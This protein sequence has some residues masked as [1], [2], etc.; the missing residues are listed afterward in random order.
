MLEQDNKLNENNINKLANMSIT[1]LQIIEKHRI[2][3]WFKNMDIQN[4]I[5]NEIEDYIYE[6]KE[7]IDF[8]ISFDSMDRI[9]EEIIKTAKSH[10]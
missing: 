1:I 3:D 2:V 8:S 9:M 4:R 7:N 5:K 6:Q 10:S